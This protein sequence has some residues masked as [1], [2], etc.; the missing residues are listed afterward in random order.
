MAEGKQ[1][2]W[3]EE[4]SGT[5]GGGTNGG[6]S[7][8][9]PDTIVLKENK[10][11]A[12][13]VENNVSDKWVDAALLFAVKEGIKHTSI[14]DIDLKPTDVKN[15][16]TVSLTWVDDK[17]VEKTTLDPTP[18]VIEGEIVLTE[19]QVID[20]ANTT[21]GMIT[22]ALLNKAIDTFGG[23]FK[24]ITI[25]N[26]TKDSD[27]DSIEIVEGYEVDNNGMKLLYGDNVL[28]TRSAD[29]AYT[30][31]GDKVEYRK[32]IKNFYVTFTTVGD[33]NVTFTGGTLTLSNTD[34]QD[35][36]PYTSSSNIPAGNY[37]L[38]GN[39][40]DNVKFI[41]NKFTKIHIEKNETQTNADNMFLGLGLMTTFTANANT[42]GNV[43]SLFNTW[44]ECKGITSFPKIDTSNVVILSGTWWFCTN[45]KS[46]PMIDTSSVTNMYSG[47]RNC[48]SLLSFPKIDTS[49]VNRIYAAWYI[50]TNLTSFPA[51]DMS[52]VTDAGYLWGSCTSLVI[53]EGVINDGTPP[54]VV[55]NM[56]YETDALTRPTAAEQNTI[57]NGGT[58]HI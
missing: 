23:L 11:S 36:V 18:I 45:L 32:H 25:P 48:T 51:L 1:D 15:T 50:C 27:G 13:D 40:V 2:P 14:T 41:N 31:I 37:A 6:G 4:I 26:G 34:T 47:W 39:N 43:T 33:T 29:D 16:F 28:Y 55:V 44:K 9:E 54:G 21:A 57:L 38:Y 20:G 35:E 42:F 22:G 7:T 12:E 24:R 53:I 8:I 46:F 56:F 10:A 52:R 19:E 30:F 58:Y 17:G 49:K 5:E 3:Y